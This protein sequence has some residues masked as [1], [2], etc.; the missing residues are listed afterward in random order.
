M[1]K[2]RHCWVH[3]IS[4]EHLDSYSWF[5]CH[6]PPCWGRGW[7]WGHQSELSDNHQ[8]SEGCK[9]CWPP[10]PPVQRR[11][12]CC[13]V[14]RCVTL[15]SPSA[16]HW[17]AYDI[18]SCAGFGF[19][20]NWFHV[21][22][23]GFWIWSLSL[24]TEK[25]S[26]HE[27]K[28]TRRAFSVQLGHNGKE[29]WRN[30]RTTLLLSGLFKLCSR[31]QLLEFHQQQNCPFTWNSEDNVQ[32]KREMMKRKS[33]LLVLHPLSLCFLITLRSEAPFN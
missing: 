20:M 16:W 4:K 1:R 33:E 21:L 3:A 11:W 28:Q 22:S 17:R 10:G 15:I 18:T 32:N 24:D 6:A 30:S 8:L 9:W 26:C 14:R 5:S 25:C 2:Y 27:S 19:W 13:C 23:A 12:C 31:G 29:Y 7:V